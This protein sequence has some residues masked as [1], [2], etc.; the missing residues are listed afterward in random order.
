M[1]LASFDKTH[2]TMTWLGV[3][4]VEGWLLHAEP[5][6]THHNLLL[7]GGIVGHNLPALVEA[8][9]PVSSGDTLIFASD[10]IR[11]DFA[12]NLNMNASPQQLVRD[13]IIRS[14]KNTDDSLVLVARYL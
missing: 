5:S 1:S 4:N 14:S 2:N 12:Q 11:N 6:L 13:I 3:G 8:T 9:I 10:G 7:R